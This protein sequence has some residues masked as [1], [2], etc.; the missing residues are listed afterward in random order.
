[1]PLDNVMRAVKAVQ[2]SYEATREVFGLLEAF[3]GMVNYCIR[4]GLEK[5]VT[6]TGLGS[7]TRSITIW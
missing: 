6:S 4:V 3:R 5:G 2:I 7:Q 1:M